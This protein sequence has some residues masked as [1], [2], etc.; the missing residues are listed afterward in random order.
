MLRVKKVALQL[1]P[2]LSS[3]RRVGSQPPRSRDR[4]ALC[5]PSNGQIIGEKLLSILVPRGYIMA[6]YI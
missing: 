3:D 1:C 6:R 4:Y 5:T 2:R